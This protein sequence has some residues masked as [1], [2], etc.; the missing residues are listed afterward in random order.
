M[1]KEASLPASIIRGCC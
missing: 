1:K